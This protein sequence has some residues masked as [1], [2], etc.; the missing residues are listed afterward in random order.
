MLLA[1]VLSVIYIAKNLDISLDSTY[2]YS[3]GEFCIK[4]VYYRLAS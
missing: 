1:V 4:Y 2:C 3:K